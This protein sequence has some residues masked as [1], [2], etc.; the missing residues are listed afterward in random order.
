MSSRYFKLEDLKVSLLH[1]EMWGAFIYVYRFR[2]CLSTDSVML[3]Q[4]QSH[5]KC[6]D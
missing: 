1:K 3:K 2:W 5:G 6:E 4:R